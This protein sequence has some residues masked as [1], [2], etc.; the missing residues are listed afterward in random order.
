[1]TTK[2]N[3]QARP[4]L[5]RATGD[6]NSVTDLPADSINSAEHCGQSFKRHSDESINIIRYLT[7][8]LNGEGVKLD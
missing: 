5:N 1:M 2:L 3:T 8:R 4:Y 7:D 6:I